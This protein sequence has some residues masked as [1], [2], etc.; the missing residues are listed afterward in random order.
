VIFTLF[1]HY[2]AAAQAAHLH[3]LH[4]QESQLQAPALQ[5][6]PLQC[7]PTLQQSA[8]QLQFPAQQAVS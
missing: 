7:F 2:M 4:A 1:S 5:H 3:G 6:S 8:V